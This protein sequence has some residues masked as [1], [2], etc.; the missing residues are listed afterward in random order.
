MSDRE[1]ARKVSATVC[2]SCSAR[3][4]A[5]VLARV[6]KRAR[7]WVFTRRDVVTNDTQIEA[8]Q[9]LWALQKCRI[10]ERTSHGIFRLLPVN[11]WKLKNEGNR[12]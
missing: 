3:V 6:T 1:L 11:N 4:I 5:K 7:G 10:I 9:S 8:A 12:A 2:G